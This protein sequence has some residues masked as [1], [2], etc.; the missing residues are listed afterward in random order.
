MGDRDRLANKTECIVISRLPLWVSGTQSAGIPG[1]PC[2][3]H[4]RV[5]PHENRGGWSIDGQNLFYR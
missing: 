1:R 2:K 3:A 5:M 4:P